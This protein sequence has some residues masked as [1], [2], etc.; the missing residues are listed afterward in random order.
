MR[1]WRVLEYALIV[2]AAM[3]L[4][5]CSTSRVDREQPSAV[6]REDSGAQ[7]VEP[8][9]VRHGIPC[10]LAAYV[11]PPEQINLCGE[12]VP[13]NDQQTKERF[14]KE[15]TIVVYGNSQVYLW[16]KRM[17][18]QLPWIEKRLQLNSL[19]DDLKYLL[20]SETDL[21]PRT[22]LVKIGNGRSSNLRFIPSGDTQRDF[23]L[24]VDQ[25]LMTLKDL[26]QQFPSWAMA[27]AAY[28]C[29]RGRLQDAIASQK[30]SDFYRLQLPPA[31][32]SYVFRIMAIKAV[33]SN[34]NRYGYNLPKGA[35]YRN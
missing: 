7:L 24:G 1:T 23:E 6:S 14:D 21:L 19:P 9:V 3:V 29:G 20:I 13:L 34:A 35:E 4:C 12:P 25:I 15:F 5:G 17:P 18:K 33:L 31:T 30:T 2:G 28:S 22:W 32:E 16:L 26:R 27:I 11:P 8:G 10:N